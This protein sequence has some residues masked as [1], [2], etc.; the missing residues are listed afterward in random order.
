M[1]TAITLIDKNT[2]ASS[3]E[4]NHH[5]RSFFDVQLLVKANYKL[6][7]KTPIG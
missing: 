5:S 7:Y 2:D 4:E 3:T 1:N 6:A